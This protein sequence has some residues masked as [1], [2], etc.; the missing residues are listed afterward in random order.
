MTY[1]ALDH[2]NQKLCKVTP[3]NFAK[4]IEDIAKNDQWCNKL[5]FPITS[6]VTA[7]GIEHVRVEM[8][9]ENLTLLLNALKSNTH[10]IEIDLNFKL[11]ASRS[12]PIVMNNIRILSDFLKENNTITKLHLSNCYLGDEGAK[13]LA[14]GLTINTK[15]EEIYLSN[16]LISDIG[17]SAIAEALKNNH[18]K[19]IDF[20]NNLSYLNYKRNSAEFTGPERP[21]MPNNISDKGL[22]AL[23]EALKQSSIDSIQSIGIDDNNVGQDGIVSLIEFIKYTPSLN[24]LSLLH[25]PDNEYVVKAMNEVLQQNHKITHLGFDDYTNHRLVKD[26]YFIDNKKYIELFGKLPSDIL[27]D[28][29]QHIIANQNFCKQA[30][31]D[32]VMGKTLSSDQVEML[33]ANLQDA[34][35]IIR[36]F[37]SGYHGDWLM[38]STNKFRSDNVPEIIYNYKTQYLDKLSEFNQIDEQHPCIIKDQIVPIGN[39]YEHHI[40]A[41]CST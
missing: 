12:Y 4:M 35:F 16:N 33:N 36:Y 25:N 31:E 17:A 2:N 23:V 28:L 7:F 29:K 37:G 18:I 15:I 3:H 32:F 6:E 1:S 14:E 39:N 38:L 30:I 26:K 8:N 40:D 22:I 19:S 27:K 9:A 11:G 34:K 41:F 21:I 24:A 5:N 13:I 20:S 10:I